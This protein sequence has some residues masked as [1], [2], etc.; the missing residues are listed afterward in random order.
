MVCVLAGLC[1]SASGQSTTGQQPSG[2]Q[3]AAAPATSSGASAQTAAPAPATPPLRLENLPPEPHTPTPEEQAEMQRQR[4]VAAINR[5]ATMQAHWGV[6]MSTPGVSLSMKEVGRTKTPQGTELTYRVSAIGFTAGEKLAFMRWPLDGNIETTMDNLTVSPSGEAICGPA[7]TAADPT[8][9]TKTMEASQPLEVKATV[10]PGEAIRIALIDADQKRGAATS[11]VP[12]PIA[13][14][15]KGCKIE[16]LLGLKNAGLVLIEGEG[17]PPNASLA[18][19][20]SSFGEKSALNAKTDPGGHLIVAMMPGV[21]GH[22]SGATTVSYQ[23]TA[24]SPSLTF[25]W[26][27]DSYKAQ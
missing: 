11:V 2:S 5:I 17:F 8:S 19:N 6:A 22:A 3:A 14:A 24:C 26:G 16:L 18:L 9:C 12:F 27:A 4:Q 21:K 15:D 10:A 20:T 13:G 1:L 25:P 7:P 23:G